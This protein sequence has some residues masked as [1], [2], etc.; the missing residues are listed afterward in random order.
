MKKKIKR[1]SKKRVY[2]STFIAVILVLLVVFLG[3]FILK[4]DYLYTGINE[5]TKRYI[6][7]NNTDST[8]I[9]KINNIT[10]KTSKNGRSILNRS[11]ILFEIKGDHHKE[12]DIVL[13]PINNTLEEKYIYYYLS[14]NNKKV[15][16]NLA[17]VLTKE[18]GGKVIYHGKIDDNNTYRLNM[19]IS[20]NYKVKGRNISYEVKIK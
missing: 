4:T 14:L 7:F 8:D 16:G 15:T 18:D 1:Y 12:F 3:L 13:Y 6:S 10:R 11:S 19:W 9:L 17:S 5:S 20:E 2:K